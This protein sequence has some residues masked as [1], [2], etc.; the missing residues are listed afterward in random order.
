MDAEFDHIGAPDAQDHED[1]QGQDPV[2]RA[3]GIEQLP[4]QPEVGAG[5]G[6]FAHGVTNETQDRGAEA[7]IDDRGQ[8]HLAQENIVHPQL[9]RGQFAQHQW[10]KDKPRSRPET[11]ENP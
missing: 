2:K 1:D 6:A 8:G 10:Q 7:E 3:R 9:W 4:E 11:I 5:V